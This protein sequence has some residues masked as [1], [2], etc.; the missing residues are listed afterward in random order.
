MKKSCIVINTSRGHT[1]DDNAL[2]YA[3]KNKKIF[4]AG[5]D[6]FKNE[7][8]IDKRYLK[9]ICFYT[10]TYCKRQWGSRLATSTIAVDNIISF[11]YKKKLIS[12]VK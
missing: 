3:L 1:V 4:A 6:V 5:L 12:E 10:S 9:L 11:F 8:K 2:I 7:P